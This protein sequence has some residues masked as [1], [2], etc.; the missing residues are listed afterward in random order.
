MLTTL[1]YTTIHRINDG[2]PNLHTQTPKAL[3]D[4]PTSGKLTFWHKYEHKHL[5]KMLYRSIHLR[6]NIDYQIRF[7]NECKNVQDGQVHPE[8]KIR[9]L[10]EHQ[11]QLE[12]SQVP[13]TE[14]PVRLNRV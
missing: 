3:K 12:R 8:A 6:N 2:L 4:T 10:K 9:I 7:P 13:T 5:E 1:L 11:H 14:R